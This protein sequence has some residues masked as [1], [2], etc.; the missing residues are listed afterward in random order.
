[1]DLKRWDVLEGQIVELLLGEQ[2]SISQA[3][4]V[5]AQANPLDKVDD[6]LLACVS[7]CTNFNDNF[8]TDDDTSEIG[9]EEK[10]E[11]IAGLSVDIAA[12]RGHGQ[13]CANLVEHWVVTSDNL[14]SDCNYP[15]K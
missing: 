7:V 9:P 15:H 8:G 5:V 10:Y 6:L 3:I 14:F 1:M 12:L 2:A 13:T 4:G 11:A